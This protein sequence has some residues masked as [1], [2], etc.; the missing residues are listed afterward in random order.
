VIRKTRLA[1]RPT[2]TC[3]RIGIPAPNSGQGGRVSRP[4]QAQGTYIDALPALVDPRTGR[5]HTPSTSRGGHGR[6]S[7]SDPNLQTS[8]PHELAIASAT[9]SW[10]IPVSDRVS[11]LSQIELRVLAHFSQDPPFST[12]LLWSG[13]PRRTA[14]EVFNVALDAVSSEQRRI[15]KPSTS[16]WFSGRPTW[17]GPNPAHRAR[18]RPR[19]IER[20][21]S[22]THAAPVHGRGIAEA[23]RTARCLPCSGAPGAAQIKSSRPRN[24]TTPSAWPATRPSRDRP[25]ICS[26]WP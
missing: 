26:S 3:W 1:R 18:R 25:P 10:L 9:P 16:A 2:R 23:R 19:Y 17:V 15:A 6:L 12:R 13:H 8:Y 21:F 14:A 4:D 22:A 20:Y 11:R 5:L 24:A 7:S